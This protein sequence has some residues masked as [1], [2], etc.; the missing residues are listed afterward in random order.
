MHTGLLFG[1]ATVPIFAFGGALLTT[2][3][4]VGVANLVDGTNASR[5]I[6]T[7]GVAVSFVVTS[8]GSLGGIFLGDPRAPIRWCSGCSADWAS[9]NGRNCPI[10]WRR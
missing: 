10:R 9:R 4:V 6:L 2:A 8:L 3:V 1:L 7:G 5:L